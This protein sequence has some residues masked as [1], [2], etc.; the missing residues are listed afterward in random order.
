MISFIIRIRHVR[1]HVHGQRV[2]IKKLFWLELQAVQFLNRDCFAKSYKSNIGIA[3]LTVLPDIG[4]SGR[5]DFLSVKKMKV[6]CVFGKGQT[7]YFLVTHP[8]PSLK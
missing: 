1:R 5:Q 3:S 8:N 2:P 7:H 6:R 4:C